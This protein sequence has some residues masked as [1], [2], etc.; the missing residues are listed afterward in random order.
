MKTRSIN[1]LAA[2]IVLLAS[3]ASRA[4]FAQTP[5]V[6]LASSDFEMNAE[7]WQGTNTANGRETLTYKTGGASSNSVG[8]ISVNE[9]SGDGQ[10]MYFAAP[11]KFLGDK[12]AAYHGLLRFNLKQSAADS[13]GPVRN[14]VYLGATNLLLAFGL[15]STPGTNWASFEVPLNEN[16]GWF[17]VTS[18][19]LA[20][21][22]DFCTVFRAV[23][24]LWICAE[25]S[26]HNSDGSDLD[27]VVLLGQPSGPVQ[28]ILA[29]GTYAGITIDGAVGSSYRIE[30][31]E[32]LD[33]SDKWQK[34]ADIVLPASPYLFVDPSSPS[35]S[36]RFYRAALNQ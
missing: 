16:V 22:E 34:M 12:R 8:Y 24:K 14:F 10:V 3:T 5:L 29:A 25:Y 11:A 2:A 4:L 20:T 31:R 35:A 1:V 6:T 23:K 21:Q 13:S 17:N 33:S 19:R 7:G 27:D 15:Y 28:P 30:Y 18:N 9:T 36:R 32:S 26:T